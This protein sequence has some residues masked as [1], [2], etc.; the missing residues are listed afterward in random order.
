MSK[1]M[2][3]ADNVPYGLVVQEFIEMMFR[4]GEMSRA[5]ALGDAEGDLRDFHRMGKAGARY[6]AFALMDLRLSG[7]AAHAAGMD[8]AGM[9]DF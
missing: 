7:Q 1:I 8:D 9:I 6:I 3:Q 5:Q 2:A 4:I